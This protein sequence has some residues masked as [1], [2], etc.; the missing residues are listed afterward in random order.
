MLLT[1]I[2]I[3]VVY[4]LWEGRKFTQKQEALAYPKRNNRLYILY[5]LICLVYKTIHDIISI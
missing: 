5:S 1:L 3:P 4:Y 2:V